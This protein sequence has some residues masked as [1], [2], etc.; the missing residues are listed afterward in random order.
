MHA[1]FVLFDG[2]TAL[3]FMGLYDPLT[4]LQP[5]GQINRGS[6]CW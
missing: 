2:L 4:R 5:D 6:P 3:D 1:A